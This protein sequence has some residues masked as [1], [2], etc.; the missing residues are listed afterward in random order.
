MSLGIEITSS[1]NVS[2]NINNINIYSTSGRIILLGLTLDA[3]F[4]KTLKKY[5]ARVPKLS[6]Y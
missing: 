1:V 5:Q 3:N 2:L 6:A 4:K